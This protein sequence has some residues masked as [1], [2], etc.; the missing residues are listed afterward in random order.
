MSA[1]YHKGSAQQPQKRAK[2]GASSKFKNNSVNSIDSDNRDYFFVE[3]QVST[4]EVLNNKTH[5]QSKDNGNCSSNNRNINNAP[6]SGS[7][8]K[9]QIWIYG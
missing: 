4:T 9:V 8:F 1:V 7:S 6:K 2:L 5:K 3:V